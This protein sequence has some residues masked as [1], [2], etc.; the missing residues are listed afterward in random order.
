MTFERWGR[1]MDEKMSFRRFFSTLSGRKS[2]SMGGWVGRM[3][4]I[5]RVV[6]FDDDEDEDE[7]AYLIFVTCSTC[8]TGVK[9]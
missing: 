2:Q 3:I 1:L 6:F 9:S 7:E 4:M 5:V 8:G